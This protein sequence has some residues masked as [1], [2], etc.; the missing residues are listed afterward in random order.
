MI[1]PVI[2]DSGKCGVWTVIRGWLSG[3]QQIVREREDRVTVELVL[4][5]LPEGA[6]WL[7]RDGERVRLIA[8]SPAGEGLGVPPIEQVTALM[9]SGHA[10]GGA[11]GGGER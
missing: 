9:W 7:D 2:R 11:A 3:R 6:L 1:I 10:V 4:R 8:R 5:D